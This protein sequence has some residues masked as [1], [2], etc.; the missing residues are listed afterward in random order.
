M[1]VLWWRSKPIKIGKKAEGGIEINE[2][3]FRLYIPSK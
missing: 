3:V 2:A 1:L